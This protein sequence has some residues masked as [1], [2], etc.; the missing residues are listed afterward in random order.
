MKTTHHYV[1]HG[2]GTT[3]TPETPSEN[4]FSSKKLSKTAA[5]QI[6]TMGLV[7][8]A[9]NVFELPAKQEFWKVG[10]DGNLMRLTKQGEVDLGDKIAAAPVDEPADFLQQILGELE[11]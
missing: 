1:A 7:R 5:T 4:H 8:V 6:S 10:E 9:G 2:V 3:Q 11:F